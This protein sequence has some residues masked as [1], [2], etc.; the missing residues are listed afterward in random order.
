MELVHLTEKEYNEF[1]CQYRYN[2]FLNSI[3]TFHL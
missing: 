1:Q 3:D 2:T